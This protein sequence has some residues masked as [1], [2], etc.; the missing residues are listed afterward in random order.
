MGKPLNRDE[1]KNAYLN[2]MSGFGIALA[3]LG[4]GHLILPHNGEPYEWA[5]YL[6]LGGVFPPLLHAVHFP[7]RH[8]KARPVVEIF[9]WGSSFAALA[10]CVF[11][12]PGGD[13]PV[14]CGFALAHW[15][16]L[17]GA[18]GVAVHDREKIGVSLFV[19]VAAYAAWGLLS[20]F[21]WWEPFGR[22][23][24]GG[25][26]Q[27]VAAILAAAFAIWYWPQD[28]V[29]RSAPRAFS[30]P[31]I[32]AE[33]A[34]IL[35][36]ALVA[37]QLPYEITDHH[38]FYVGSAAL[39]RQGGWLLWDVPSQ[40]GFLDILLL[41]ALPFKSLHFSLYVA[42]SALQLLCALIMYGM[43]RAL[44][45]GAF[46]AAAGT[47]LTITVAFMAVDAPQHT[48]LNTHPSV[49]GMRFLFCYLF[50]AWSYWNITAENG[51]GGARSARFWIGSCLWAVGCLWS[52]ESAI[53]STSIWLPQSLWLAWETA[54]Q[55]SGAE[56]TGQ[57]R[58]AALIF[59]TS[60]LPLLILFGAVNA[61]Y[62]FGLG[63]LPDW[64]AF[65][66]YA[67]V[68]KGGFGALPI[69]PLGGVWGLLLVFT[70]VSACAAT[71]FRDRLK[72]W[73][74]LIG[75]MGLIWTTASYFIS[76]SA[77]SNLLNLAPI[78]F[79]CV[80]TAMA[81]FKEKPA[82]RLMLW[83]V[84]IPLSAVL[85]IATWGSPN[86]PRFF[87]ETFRMDHAS[88]FYGLLPKAEESFVDI[89]KEVN[90]K[91]GDPLVVMTLMMP[92]PLA[93]AD[94][95]GPADDI[96]LYRFWLPMAPTGEFW[97]L[98]PER[99]TIYI[100][101]FTDRFREGG[102]LVIPHETPIGQIGGFFACI[103]VKYRMTLERSNNDWLV[104]RY[105]PR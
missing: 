23:V 73:P 12:V 9:R 87:H 59:F 104:R 81:A 103:D 40:Y 96:G 93:D 76:R 90:Y 34:L 101:R 21:F 13:I 39:V 44:R 82:H 85:L 4:L 58:R 30:I 64:Y 31:R 71:A 26:Q 49:S 80:V 105:E 20:R 25:A 33:L 86:L 72:E 66:E 16:F 94:S 56:N 28:A 38:D 102:L 67:A 37:F 43:L 57:W 69:E 60:L 92:P 1:L 15:F 32:L 24:T 8:A 52:F 61:F 27:V 48:G 88:R 19:L 65:I 99:R 98:P 74:A 62:I 53:Y 84:L 91:K 14:I 17:G 2:L 42:A 89:L 54:K 45:P 77:E 78:H 100:S 29:K 95:K 50:L 46:G 11:I 22:F 47:L 3:V 35:I 18:N 68:Y 41:A 83:A 70:A 6:L 51:A 5:Q 10:F 63:H 7:F 97:L 75:I 55:G 79:T 36:L